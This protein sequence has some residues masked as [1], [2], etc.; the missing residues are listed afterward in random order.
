MVSFQNQRDAYI[1]KINKGQLF[2]Q[3]TIIEYDLIDEYM[4]YQDVHDVSELKYTKNNTSSIPQ[5][6]FKKEQCLKYLKKTDNKDILFF[7][8]DIYSGGAKDF[9]ALSKEELYNKLDTD[10]FSNNNFYESWTENTP[11]SFMLDM[12]IPHDELESI[13]KSLDGVII[14]NIQVVKEA[15]TNHFNF[16]NLNIYI[17]KT[18][19]QPKK[20]SVHIVFK[21][22]IFE[23][24]KV[25]KSFYNNILKE[26]LLF[27]DNSIYNLTCIRMVFN[28]KKD[29]PKYSLLPYKLNDSIINDYDE[30]EY[31]Y[32][33]LIT[34]N[35]SNYKVINK[36]YINDWEKKSEVDVVVHTDNNDVSNKEYKD[37]IYRLSSDYCDEYS[38]WIKVIT[39]GKKCNI[40]Y[41]I[42]DV[43]SKQS[44]KYNK[45]NNLSIYKN[46]N[47][48]TKISINSLQYYVN[49]C[50]K[51][52][53]LKKTISSYKKMDI[54][55]SNIS[56]S[57]DVAK[58][59]P[60]Y[61]EEISNYKLFNIQSEKGTG[62][63]YNLIKTLF[64]G[65]NNIVDNKRVLF[66]SSRRTFGI[67]LQSDLNKYGFK[68][69]SDIE[70]YSIRDERVICQINSLNRIQLNNYDIIIID[71]VESLCKYILSDHFTQNNCSKAIYTKLEYILQQSKKVIIMDADLSNRSVNYIRGIMGVSDDE[72]YTLCNTNKPGEE[73]IICPLQFNKWVSQLC[74][75]IE[76]DKKV[77]IPMASNSKAKDIHIL[78]SKKFPQ[79]RIKLICKETDDKEKLQDLLYVNDTWINYDILIYTP[80]VCMGVSFDKIHFDNI[81]AYGCHNSLSHEE[82]VQMLHRVRSPKDK[83]IFLTFDKYTTNES[84]VYTNDEVERIV[85]YEINLSQYN[86]SD[87]LL[88]YGMAY[89]G[90][91][92]CYRYEYVNKESPI[93]KTI[94]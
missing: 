39:I 65:K 80:T 49:E 38:K 82:F 47:T 44:N 11:L 1:S 27:C 28:S 62:K 14:H 70:K 64:E 17:H 33:C 15:F 71:E 51:I 48:S 30:E 79:K 4:E 89:D 86:I 21:S 23:N 77:V 19:K 63:T 53:S 40:D 45:K 68:L 76:N 36:S 85:S 8:R 88:V 57:I 90:N 83:N 55:L 61:F 54:E 12:D 69:Y 32:D 78:L 31:F 91:N 87:N 37:M 13:N 9:W 2:K 34:N 67:K 35:D 58:L 18:K 29:K 66:L 24:H 26:K 74:E 6:F 59:T 52:V 25:V 46:I 94:H 81:F 16:N 75:F 42:I 93:Y 50:S 22:I 56:K 41:D 10:D 72:T 73:Y 20:N 43:W 3:E 92:E 5:R 60:E 84:R 7:Q